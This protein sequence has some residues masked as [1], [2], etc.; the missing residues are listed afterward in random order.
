MNVWIPAGLAAA[1]AGI[2]LH[3]AYHPNSPVFGPALGRGDRSRRRIYLTFDD[4][5]GPRGT[6]RILDILGGAGVP[7][8]FFQVGRH[9][10][11][12]PEIA[13]R[14]AEAG[15]E[16][17]NHTMTHRKLHCAGPE[18]IRRELAEAGAAIAG[19]TG[20]TPRCFRAPH[21]LRNPFVT[22][23]ARRAGCTV[24][25]WTFGVWDSARPG[26]ATIRDRVR[27]GLRPGAIVLLHDGDGAD[28]AGDRAQTAEALPDILEDARDLGYS[29][30]ALAEIL[31][32]S[33][34]AARGGVERTDH[35]G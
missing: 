23:A 29:F 31:P 11:R 30:G 8:A 28:P 4:G 20:V 15:Q 22:G 33:N 24:V 21:G 2:L 9:V 7:A 18:T 32:S 26:A 13:R 6:E 16:I 5:P 34:A 12:F 19:E 14:V 10:R 3:G 27:R 35:E 17:G 25:G 1:T